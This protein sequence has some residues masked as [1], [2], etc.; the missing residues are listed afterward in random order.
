MV[1][2]TNTLF[3]PMIQELG[4]QKGQHK[5]WVANY[6]ILLLDCRHVFLGRVAQHQFGCPTNVQCTRDVRQQHLSSHASLTMCFSMGALYGNLG[7]MMPDVANCSTVAPV[8]NG[9][10]VQ[11]EGSNTRLLQRIKLQILL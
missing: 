6:Y 5:G 11:N 1:N 7:L 4:V 10:L 2:I 8:G 3:D 9:L